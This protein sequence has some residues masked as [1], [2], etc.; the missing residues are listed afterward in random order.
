MKLQRE[1]DKIIDKVK[2]HKAEKEVKAVL[3]EALNKNVKDIEPISLAEIQ[4][5]GE[6]SDEEATAYLSTRMKQPTKEV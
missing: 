2:Q 4:K 1:E 6:M 3:A 5:I